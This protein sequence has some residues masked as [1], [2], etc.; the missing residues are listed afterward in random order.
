MDDSST[1]DTGQKSN[2]KLWSQMGYFLVQ[3]LR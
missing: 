3:K 1:N 2:K